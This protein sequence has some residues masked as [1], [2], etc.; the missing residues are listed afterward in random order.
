MNRRDFISGTAFLAA[1]G[2]ARA[3]K[4][5]DPDEQRAHDLH[6]AAKV[7]KPAKLLDSPPFLQAPAETSVGVAFA[8]TAFSL[9]KVAVAD[10]PEMRN[11]RTFVSEG[12]PCAG[13][14][15]RIHTVRVTGLRPATTYCYRI[16]AAS[17]GHPVGYW[18]K[19]SE[20]E[21]SGVYR[22]TTPGTAALSRFAVI[23]DTH[24]DWAR[25]GGVYACLKRFGAP[26][27]VWNGDVPP[28]LIKDEETAVG[29]YLKQPVG[30][31]D[32]AATAPVLFVRG[33]HDFRGAWNL[34]RQA[35]L[36]MARPAAER[37]AK[38]ASL[39][40]NFAIRQGDIALIGLDTGED[41][42][43]W[44]PC[45]AGCASYSVYRKLQTE[46]LGDQFRRPE[47]AQAPH[48]VVFCHIP[49]FD[50]DPKANPGDVLEDW[51]D[52]RRDC[53]ELWGPILERNCVKV[54]IAG[55][56]HCYRCDKPAAGRSWTQICGGGPGDGI[57][58][59]GRRRFPT[60]IGG[61]VRDGKLVISVC[62]ALD[63]SVVATHAFA[64]R[65]GA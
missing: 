5:M 33:N 15:S 38:Y 58:R 17:L 50:P 49:L 43:D 36:L 47:I 10:N 20:T 18:M 41:K 13:V 53:A 7:D 57:E 2:L 54:V 16:G 29:Y 24:A 21:W 35:D 27:T 11:A 39:I 62:N 6:A 9:G 25:L 32:H 44:H 12:L 42:P 48:V 34:T 64:D 14:S 37:D 60:V 55:H 26:V 63:G 28:S 59:K 31:A 22:F 19:P 30:D 40:R 52:W 61:E 3:A 4:A 46:W 65:A 45:F 51:A 1:A 23:N 56:Q 8:V